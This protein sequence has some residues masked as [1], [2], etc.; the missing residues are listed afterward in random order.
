MPRVV[1]IGGGAAGLQ[2][3]RSLQSEHG[4]AAADVLVIEA[5]PQ[6]GGRIRQ[7]ST[8]VPGHLV[9]LGAEFVHGAH[10]RL[11]ALSDE[12][13][14]DLEELFTWAHGDGGPSEHPAA[15]GGVGAYY[16]GK[17]KKLLA[18]DSDDAEFVHLNETLREMCELPKEQTEGDRRT[19][20]QY[21]RDQNVSSRVSCNS[22]DFTLPHQ[23]DS[24]PRR[25]R[26][27]VCEQ[28]A[29]WAWL[30][31]MTDPFLLLRS[32]R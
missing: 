2:C 19:L 26:S 25:F 1:I 7:S 18:F 5:M 29:A 4:V 17:E 27:R 9:E 22:L 8:F 16:L 31:P 32:R 15:D 6:L 24:G 11:N 20:G 28:R 14:W 30:N 23:P 13:G 3:A 10:T 12:F 21:L